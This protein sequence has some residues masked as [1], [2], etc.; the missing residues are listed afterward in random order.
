MDIGWYIPGVLSETGVVGTNIDREFILDKDYKAGRL[1]LRLKTPP[2]PGG[3]PCQIDIN[4]DG[5]SIFPDEKPFIASSS[6]EYIGWSDKVMAKDSVITL[7]IDQ[8][9]P[10]TPGKDLTIQL[11]LEEA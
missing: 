4:D 3:T 5:E 8:V 9:S 7:D 10:T 11:E 1:I 2:A 6:R